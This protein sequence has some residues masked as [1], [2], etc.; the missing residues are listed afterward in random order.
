MKIDPRAEWQQEFTDAWR[1]L[2]DWFYDP[3]MHGVDWNM[4]RQRYGQLVPYI[5]HRS[6]LDYI[7]GEVG[8]E[9]NSGHVYVSTPSDWQVKRVENGLLG[10]VIVP[11]ASGYYRIAHIFPGENWHESFRSPL[12]EPGVKVHEGDYILA[13]DGATTKGVDNFYRLLENKANRIV[14]LLVNSKPEPAGAR[15]EKVR[16]TSKETDLRYLDWVDSRRALVDKLS[17]GRIGYIHLPDT[18]NEGNQA[19]VQVLLPAGRQGRPDHRRSLQRRR[20][21]PRPDDRAARPADPQLLGRAA[22]RSPRRR[23]PTRTPGRR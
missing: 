11:D 8:G 18:A 2:R 3:N 4:V 10:A 20:I 15:E 14:T 6:D 12:T 19:A 13:V 23:R 16:P 1:I 9:V 22:A 17:G 7:L 21:H 5:A